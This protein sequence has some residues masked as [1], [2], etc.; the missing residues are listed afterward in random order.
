MHLESREKERAKKGS[1]KSEIKKKI[2]A[3]FFNEAESCERFE[4]IWKKKKL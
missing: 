2:F 4:T 1:K 3:K